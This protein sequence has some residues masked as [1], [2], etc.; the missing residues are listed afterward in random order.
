MYPLIKDIQF[1]STLTS[2]FCLTEKDPLGYIGNKYTNDSINIQQCSLENIDGCQR[3][4]NQT[5]LFRLGS[6]AGFTSEINNIIRGFIYSINTH[7]KFLINDQYWNY[8]LFSSFFN[9]S[10]GHFSPWLPLSSYCLQRQF[11]HVNHY[12]SNNKYI[13]EHIAVGRD[14]NGN[15]SSLYWIMKPF[16]ENNQADELLLNI[17]GKH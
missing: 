3:I 13:P 1:Y 7:R 15:Y 5:L 12:T 14:S 11:V 8:G 9:M 17:Y 2:A 4:F 6:S 10:Q 16:E